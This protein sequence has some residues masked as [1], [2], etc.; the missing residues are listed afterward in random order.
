[1]EPLVL[2]PK[3]SLAIMNGTSAMAGIA[4]LVVARAERLARLAAA[5]TAMTSAATLGN[6]EH[7]D[8][9]VLGLK[10]HA[11]TMAAGA[12][13]RT[14]LHVEPAGAS[15]TPA[16]LQDRYSVRCAPHVLGVLVDAIV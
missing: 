2:A 5:V 7:F 6:P 8:E 1:L 9:G 3:E 4:S 13:I 12:W 10:P 11:G 16:R 14:F 15:P